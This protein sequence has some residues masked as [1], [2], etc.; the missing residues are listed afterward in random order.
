M[1]KNEK[2]AK[3]ASHHFTEDL[4]REFDSLNDTKVL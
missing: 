1:R 4:S 2:E 3:L